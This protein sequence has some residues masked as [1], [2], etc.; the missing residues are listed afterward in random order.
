MR[1]EEREGEETDLGLDDAASSVVHGVEVAGGLGADAGRA[2]ASLG[3]LPARHADELVA[4]AR[5]GVAGHLEGVAL[6]DGVDDGRR[7]ALGLPARAALLD[8]PLGLLA[9]GG[10]AVA[11]P[12]RRAG[13]ASAEPVG[14]GRGLGVTLPAWHADELVA[15]TGLSVALPAGHADELVTPAGLGV[16]LHR[17]GG[18][19]VA[20]PARHADELIAPAGVR[21]GITLP[22]GHANELVAPAGIGLALL[23]GVEAEGVEELGGVVV[24]GGDGEGQLVDLAGGDGGGLAAGL[25]AGGQVEVGLDGIGKG[26]GSALDGVAGLALG[27]AVALVLLHDGRGVDRDRDGQ[28]GEGESELHGVETGAKERLEWFRMNVFS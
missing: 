12:A 28:D 25:A 5:V 23:G 4:P 14:L 6:V 11:L 2:V 21:L 13:E 9:G 27:V 15:P 8:A 26:G 18:G 19:L 3:A 1:R 17:N 10:A 16:A 7:R 24:A 22:A 20:L